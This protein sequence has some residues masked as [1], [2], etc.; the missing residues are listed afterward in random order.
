MTPAV[1]E[2]A[3]GNDVAFDIESTVLFGDQMFSSAFESFDVPRFD[4]VSSDE[5][6]AVLVPHRTVAVEA[7]LE[8]PGS[9]LPAKLSEMGWHSGTTE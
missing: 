7:Q 4:L 9:S 2:V 6:L 5:R 3:G 1:A 8:L